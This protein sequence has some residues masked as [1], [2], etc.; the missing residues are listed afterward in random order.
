MTPS[1]DSEGE[2]EEIRGGAHGGQS[3][4]MKSLSSQSFGKGERGDTS[5]REHIDEHLEEE[6]EETNLLR[7]S[8]R[9]SRE[10]LAEDYEL[11]TPDEDKAV[12]RSLDRRLVLFMALLYLLS[13][14]DRSSKVTSTPTLWYRCVACES[15]S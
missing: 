8:R 13:F 4:R 2:E 11:Y 1:S 3:F 6:E 12:L 5:S 15:I 7:G 14:L 9:L 10:S